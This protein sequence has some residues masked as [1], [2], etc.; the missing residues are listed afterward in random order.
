[1]EYLGRH[2][3]GQGPGSEPRAV[4]LEALRLAPS[5]GAGS[6][7]VLRERVNNKC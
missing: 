3:P 6:R 5:L 2:R 4:R 1:M 7:S